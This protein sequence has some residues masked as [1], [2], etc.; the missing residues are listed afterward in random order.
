MNG[1]GDF[2]RPRLVAYSQYAANW[3]R[4]FSRRCRV[5]KNEL[6]IETFE[7]ATD[8]A[9]PRPDRPYFFHI[10]AANGDIIAPSQ[11]Y[12]SRSTRNRRA[13]WWQKRLGD[14]VIRRLGV[15]R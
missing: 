1:K 4:V 9:G 13:S 2:P 11:G 15:Q 14:T 10:K 5:H 8:L 7:H 6:V 12:T 3:D